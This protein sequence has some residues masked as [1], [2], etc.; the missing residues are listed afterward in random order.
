MH[1]STRSNRNWLIAFVVLALAMRMVMP[2]GWMPSF[3]DGRA[4]ITLCTSAGMVEAWVDADG[5]IHKEHPAKKGVGDQP[6][7]FAGL[8]AAAE[9]PAFAV[10]SLAL[11]FAAQR[12]LDNK[13]TA[14]A[15]GLG[16]AAPPPPATAPPALI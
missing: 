11:P 15:I 3:A 9:A 6:C 1:S 16:L 5:K 2:A 13:A 7:A 14:V 10:A 12:P 8:G 4:T